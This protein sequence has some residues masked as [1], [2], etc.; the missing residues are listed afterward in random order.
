MIDILSASNDGLKSFWALPL[1]IMGIPFPPVAEKCRVI[2]CSTETIKRQRQRFFINVSHLLAYY[3]HTGAAFVRAG[4]IRRCS[5]LRPPTPPMSQLCRICRDSIT[6]LEGG[7]SL[8]VG[9]GAIVGVISKAEMRRVRDKPDE[10]EWKT[11]K[12]CG[13]PDE[14]WPSRIPLHMKNC[15]QEQVCQNMGIFNEDFNHITFII[16]GWVT[17]KHYA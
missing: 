13:T 15:D 11:A 7:W 1:D 2:K 8:G 12:T 3:Y 4:A 14:I 5:P 9:V 17:L 16:F 6:S 10:P